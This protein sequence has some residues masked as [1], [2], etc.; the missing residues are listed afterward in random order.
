MKENNPKE[1]RE[2]VF[3][4]THVDAMAVSIKLMAAHPQWHSGSRIQRPVLNAVSC[5]SSWSGVLLSGF[6]S[7]NLPCSLGLSVPLSIRNIEIKII[8]LKHTQNCVTSL[9]KTLQCLLLSLRVKPSRPLRVFCLLSPTSQFP[10]LAHAAP[11]TLASDKTGTFPPS[12]LHVRLPFTET[13][14]S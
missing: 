7:S 12:A 4:V 13:L 3:S 11:A 1:S 14:F 2:M 9:W 6:A 8:F 5:E 10:P